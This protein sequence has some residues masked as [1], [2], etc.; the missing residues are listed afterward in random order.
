MESDP[1]PG[2]RI[3]VLIPCYNEAPTI[4]GVVTAFRAELPEAVIHVFDNGSTDASARLAAEA[5]ATVTRVARRGKGYVVQSM[6]RKIEAD[7]YL[8][9]D[10]DAT[11]PASAARALLGPVLRGEA[12]MVVGSRLQRESGSEF[13]RINRWGNALFLKIFERLF[14]V[15]ITDLLSGYRAFSPRVVHG[16][17]LF[18][19]GFEVEAELTIKSLQRGFRIVETPVTLTARPEGSRSKLRIFRDGFVILN[20]MLTLARDYKP[21]TVFATA[22]GALIVMAV[23][24]A[25]AS[26]GTGSEAIAHPAVLA[27]AGGLAL[28]GISSVFTGLVL[29]TVARHFQELDFV[30]RRDDERKK[31]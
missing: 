25:A 26:L 5:G 24:F 2:R 28:V 31:E 18:G 22:G 19:G 21:L 14:R 29:H 7:A 4:G 27:I 11:Y 9:V 17:P 16:L 1:P 13:R 8:M 3:A 15:P 6:F 12:E 30:L 20:L 23:V 10:G